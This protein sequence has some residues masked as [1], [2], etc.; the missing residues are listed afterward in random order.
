MDQHTLLIADSSEQFCHELRNILRWN[1]QIQTCRSGTQ[2]LSIISQTHPDILVLDLMLPELDGLAVLKALSASGMHPAIIATSCLISD[3]I[4]ESAQKLNVSYLVAK[5][6]SI[7]AV[8]ARVQDQLHHLFCQEADFKDLQNR[9]SEI[10]IMMG[11]SAKLHGFKYLRLAV[12]SVLHDP[13]QSVTKE[14]Y[15]GVASA[16][17]TLGSHVE[18]SIRGAIQDAW[19]KRDDRIWQ[20]YFPPDG[21]GRISKP[22]NAA[23]I[24]RIADGLR[25]S[26]QETGS[27]E[28]ISS[29]RALSS[30]LPG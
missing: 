25:I 8:A 5:P 6:C 20:L 26:L 11:F 21:L 14:L 3:Y 23:F 12:E 27:L 10:L 16:C 2:A 30:A 9:I 29:D 13:D 22:T 1:C 4:L 19:K 18:R 15:P 28:F 7:P 24:S 17:G